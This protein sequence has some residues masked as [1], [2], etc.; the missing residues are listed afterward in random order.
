MESAM[1]DTPGFLRDYSEMTEMERE[2]KTE[3]LISIF[4]ELVGHG[5]NKVKLATQTYDMVK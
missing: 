4:N 5:Q 3:S 1:T 2:A